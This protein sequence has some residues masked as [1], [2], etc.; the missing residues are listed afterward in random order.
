MRSPA[1]K[2]S[3]FIACAK[4]IFVALLMVAGC[5]ACDHG[6]IYES[7]VD[8]P[9]QGWRRTERARFEVD[10]T[11]TVSP[12]NIYINVRNRSDYP[13][14]QLWLFVDV[15][16]PLGTVERDTARITLA[17]HRGRWQGNGLGS[18]F[19]TRIF[20]RKNVRFPATGKYIF[21]YEQA[22]RDESLTGIDDIGL[23]IERIAQ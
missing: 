21:E 23:R 13:Y 12:C 19:D 16:S 4:P 8:I 7:N 10:I 14:M 15:H 6:R 11:D 17:D 9:R 2:L 22:T 1:Y 18:K 3:S 5:Y 20:L